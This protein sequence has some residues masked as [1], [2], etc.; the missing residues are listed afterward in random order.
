MHYSIIGEKLSHTFSPHIHALFGNNSYGKTELAPHELDAFMQKREFAGISVTMPYKKAVM[1]HCAVLS[2]EAKRIGCVNCVVNHN[3][4]LHGHNTDYYG[5]RYLVESSGISLS[6][7]KV[8]VL[9]SGGA[10]LTARAVAAD[11]DAAQVIV[12]SR[13]G[14]DNYDNIAKHHDA[15]VIIN[16]TPVGMSPNIGAS[17]LDLYAFASLSGVIDVVY[18]PLRT[19][20]LLQAKALG[21]PYANGLPMLVAQAKLAHELFFNTTMA[22][23]LF[24]D[25]LKQIEQQFGNIVLI[26]MPGC[27]KSHTAA[28]IAVR[29]NMPYVDIDE[30]VEKAEGIPPRQIIEQRGEPTFRE[31]EQHIISQVC[32]RGGQVI[33]TGG[34][35][36]LSQQNR[37]ALSRNGTI[38]WLQRDLYKLATDGRPL[39][40]DGAAL[41]KLYADRAPIYQSLCDRAVAVKDSIVETTESILEII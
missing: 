17:P 18:N 38:I 28:A 33:A 4:E 6:G 3:G 16:T 20:L 13:N 37:D 29:L 8:L 35:S 5:F 14:D 11:M 34:G 36:V 9:G 23:D 15:D 2:D 7:K 12:I 40:Q 1:P 24:L 31:I 26:G 10:S 22:D 32:S 30:E 27:G 39:S 21:I 25:T 19:K 41:E